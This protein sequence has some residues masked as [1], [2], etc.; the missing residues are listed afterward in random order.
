M[1]PMSAPP[2]TA[3]PGAEARRA[4]LAAK[5]NHEHD[6]ACKDT[7]SAL[8]HVVAAGELLIEAKAS[9]PHGAWIP[10]VRDHTHVSPRQAQKYMR[11]ARNKSALGAHLTLTEALIGLA[12]AIV[13]TEEMSGEQMRFTEELGLTNAKDPLWKPLPPLYAVLLEDCA[14]DLAT[15]LKLDKGAALLFAPT[16]EVGALGLAAVKAVNRSKSAASCLRWG[17]GP[18]LSEHSPFAPSGATGLM[19][20]ILPVS[21]STPPSSVARSAGWQPC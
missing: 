16:Y 21:T 10:W 17:R 18:N 1:T 19:C 6:L 15:R 11:V 4:A 8:E 9:L 20:L 2:S 5:I 14:P 12:H 7:R 13:D 3:P